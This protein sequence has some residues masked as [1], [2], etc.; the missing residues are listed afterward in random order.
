L[1]PEIRKLLTPQVVRQLAARWPEAGATELID[2]VNSVVFAFQCQGRPRILRLTHSSQ[3]AEEDTQA[4]LDWVHFLAENG[5]PVAKPVV[6]SSGAFTEILP[7]GDSYFVAAV[8]ERAEGELVDPADPEH[9]NPDLIRSMGRLM[10]RM[11]AVTKRYD[12]RHLRKKRP[13]W[14]EADV[15]LH[16]SSYVPRSEAQL[17]RDLATAVERVGRLPRDIDGY[18]LVHWDLNPTNYLV[19]DGQITLFDCADCC[20]GWF[21]G[22]IAAGM[23]FYQPTYFEEDW[24]PRAVAFF[25]SLMLG[26]NEEN[27]LPAFWFDH[28]GDFL[29]LQNM[30]NLVFCFRENIAS[31]PYAWFFELVRDVYHKGHRPY[32]LDFRALYEALGR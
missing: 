13:L 29:K 7:A 4:E 8:F 21:I 12:P 14:D 9:G 1:K 15:L 31:G 18:G 19:K 3:A 26:Y 22:D 32:D 5:V 24:E 11:H 27:D 2:D 16:A 20:Y 25:Q 10:G 17:V 30:L 6:S 28:L 23:L